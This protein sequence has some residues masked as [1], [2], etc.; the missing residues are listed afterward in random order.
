MTSQGWQAAKRLFDEARRLDAGER[1]T[2][3]ADACAGDEELRR[4][5]ESLLGSY[6]EAGDFIS[7]PAGRLAGDAADG[8]DEPPRDLGAYRLLRAIGRG[9]MGTVYLAVRADEA[10]HQQVA[11]K[12]LR[13]GI[14]TDDLVTRFRRERQILAR[15]EHPNIARL[16]DG[17]SGEDG[18]P[19]LVMEYVEGVSIDRFCDARHLSVEQR[20]ELFRKVCATI[21]F[22]H[23]N[24]VVHRDLKPSN[25]LVTAAGE[26]KLLDFG[27][28]KLLHPEG[29]PQTSLV[30]APGGAPMTPQYASP[31]QVRGDAITTASDVYALGVVLYE[32]LTGQRPYRLHGQRPEDV[33]RAVC[34]ALPERPSIA[35][36]RPPERVAAA[37]ETVTVLK[38]GAASPVPGSEQRR[39]RRRLAGDLDNIV[40]M[41]LRKEPERRYGSVE[42]FSRDLES[43]LRGWPVLARK[44]TFFYRSG[45][46]VRRH[47]LA[48]ASAASI[49]A[50]LIGFSVTLLTQ[51]RA[52]LEQR[53]RAEQVSELVIDIFAL[54]D[55]NR[56]RGEAI[57][58][59]EVLD[60]VSRRMETE[61]E[62]Q[63]GVK[64]DVLETMGRSYKNLALYPE[65]VELLTGS[66]ELR[67]DLYGPEHPSVADSLQLLADIEM[68]RGKYRQGESI[69]RR[70]LELRRRH[71]GDEHE[72]VAESLFR[73]A[74][75]LELSGD[76]DDAE[77]H[78]REAL[79]IARRRGS[80][81]TLA[82]VLDRFAILFSKRD[83]DAQAA[84]MFTEA[85]AIYD[86]LHGKLHPESALV[87]N[88]LA[89]LYKNRGDLERAELLF[90]RAEEIQRQVFDGAHSHLATTLYNRALLFAERGRYD[91]AEALYEEA[92]AMRREVYR[93][94]H[95]VIALTLDNLAKLHRER[96]RYD[97]AETLH[98]EA[99]A[100]QLRLLGEEHPD[101]AVTR[102]NLAQLLGSRGDFDAAEELYRQALLGARRGLGERHSQVAVLLNNLGDTLLSQGRRGGAEEA[103]REAL[104]IHREAVGDDHPEVAVT[105]YNLA[106][107][108]QT[109]GDAAAAE[110]SY[111]EALAISLARFGEDHPKVAKI[112]TG[113]ASL[114]HAEKRYAEAVPLAEA[115][116]RHF[117]HTLGIDSP[118]TVAARRTFGLA[119]LGEGRFAEAEPHLLWSLEQH[120]DSGSGPDIVR[121]ALERLIELYDSWQRNEEEARYRQLL[122]QARS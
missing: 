114:L 9:G 34:E 80:P 87:R 44:D 109:R 40:L 64:A 27:I 18:R 61:L 122:E 36:A 6:D 100:M 90:R 104:S 83:E 73:L 41:A 52:I 7:R 47:K 59:R 48:V 70:A 91:E 33:A 54:P 23:Q 88:N 119:L 71:Y 28:A 108:E 92:L 53:G 115:A 22:A 55:P 24:L 116:V 31:E 8:E 101:I 16:H 99:L 2:F 26:P 37:A 51:R 25:I 45:K 17:G 4:E 56:A 39:L 3:L 89:L 79:A 96:G 58:A 107:L 102:G 106:V 13:R 42:Q 21:Q 57:T 5:V 69:N 20:L 98:R 113:F 35:A 112:R 74:R 60:N 82:A 43:H 12:V 38:P 103:F 10:Y 19:Y 72:L 85:L 50:L 121:K 95:P 110:A 15:L 49:V 120:R 46:F 77:E 97:A 81:E 118:W 84:A 63:P 29:F 32:L 105:L 1:S 62:G 65:A 11:V 30:T 86:E 111:S 93:G 76:L 117:E 75:L 94:E 66:L 78:Y 14:D 67:R 68:A